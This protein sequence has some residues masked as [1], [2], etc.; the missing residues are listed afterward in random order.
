MNITK[1][2]E[3]QGLNQKQITVYLAILGLGRATVIDIARKTLIKRTTV[4]DIVMQ[5]LQL[6][7]ISESKNGRR[8]LFIAEDP[9]ILI[10]KNEEKLEELKKA[11]PFLANIYQ[12]NISKPE[13]KFYDG[14]NGVKNIMEELLLIKSKEQLFWSSIEDLVD[15]F[16]ELYMKGW[17]KRRIKKGIWSKVLLVRRKD[18]LEAEF[19]ASEAQLREIHWLPKNFTPNGIICLVDN[20][21]A[22][23]SSKKESFGFIVESNDLSYMMKFVFESMWQITN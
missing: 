19:Q 13:I 15:L 16:G 21:I 2:L 4:Y 17:V 9:Q 8:R 22:F 6:G 10:A 5:L 7:F 20:K 3:K 1:D 12:K 14:I 18:R 23:I 11:V